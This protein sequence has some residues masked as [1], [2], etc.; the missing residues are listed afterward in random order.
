M[1]NKDKIKIQNLADNCCCYINWFEESGGEVCRIK[2]KLYLY[3]IL[4]VG[5]H[6]AGVFE[7]NEVDKLLDLAYSWT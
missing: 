7:L 2:D 5:E 3:E 4:Y 1:R 6:I